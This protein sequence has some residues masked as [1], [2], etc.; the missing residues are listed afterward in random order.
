MQGAAG[1]GA[2]HVGEPPTNGL[3]NSSTMDRE[4]ARKTLLQELVTVLEFEKFT[5]TP[6]VESVVVGEQ[7]IDLRRYWSNPVASA[8]TTPLHSNNTYAMYGEKLV[9]QIYSA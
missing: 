9:D 1:D 2:N 8:T 4:E 3:L 7:C 5:P 6:G